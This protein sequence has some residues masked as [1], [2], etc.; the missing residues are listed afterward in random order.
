[1]E[2]LRGDL[3]RFWTQAL[4]VFRA[5]AEKPPR[6]QREKQKEKKR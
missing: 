6:A 3:D 1:L 4:D 5:V 2:T